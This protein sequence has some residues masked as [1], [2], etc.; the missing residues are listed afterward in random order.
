VRVAGEGHPVTLDEGD[1]EALRVIGI[2]LDEVRRR[3]EATFGAGALERTASARRRRRGRGRACGPSVGHIPFTPRAKKVL[4]LAL[5][6]AKALRHD[7]IGTEHILLGLVRERDGLAAGMLAER[8]VSDE[9]VRTVV[10]ELLS[11]N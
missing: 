10:S 9:R 7:Y 2:D 11:G 8:D 6:E 4:E 5:R 1:A 3:I